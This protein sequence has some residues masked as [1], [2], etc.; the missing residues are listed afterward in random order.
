MNKVVH[1]SKAEYGKAGFSNSQMAVKLRPRHGVKMNDFWLI[2]LQHA[3]NRK[4]IEALLV[5]LHS[6]NQ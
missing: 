6:F 4:N 1:D 3:V 5:K 2:G